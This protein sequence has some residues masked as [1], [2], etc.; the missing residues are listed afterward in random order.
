MVTFEDWNQ[1]ASWGQEDVSLETPDLGMLE[2]PE[3]TLEASEG[4]SFDDWAQ[5]QSWST[6]GQGFDYSD[7]ISELPQTPVQSAQIDP[8]QD[9]FQF[10][11]QF[12]SQNPNQGDPQYA[13]ADVPENQIQSSPKPSS[14]DPFEAW[15]EL[16]QGDAEGWAQQFNPHQ[17]LVANAYEIGKA[18]A[19][20]QGFDL[21][22]FG[23]LNLSDSLLGNLWSLSKELS[24]HPETAWD[25]AGD[26]PQL[27]ESLAKPESETSPIVSNV[28]KSAET[29]VDL[30][31]AGS[32]PELMGVD[33]LTKSSPGT[34]P[35]V[36][37]TAEVATTGV[38]LTAPEIASGASK[39]LLGADVLPSLKE[40]LSKVLL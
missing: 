3:P 25:W 18:I 9:A 2:S 33:V 28:I 39:E 34:S 31:A 22:V 16:N 1:V 17:S 35:V 14:E 40:L 5:I 20:E 38:D 15:N 13:P 24:E 32:S 37:Q 27:L 10:P 29:G 19:E 26:F 21:G 11:F 23:K 6:E 30:T 12:P 8:A 4:Q 36:T 7:P